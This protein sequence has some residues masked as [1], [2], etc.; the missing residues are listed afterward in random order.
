MHLVKDNLVRM[1][2]APKA[3]NE[4]EGGHDGNSKL[5]V[6]FTTLLLRLV[7]LDLLG[8]TGNLFGQRFRVR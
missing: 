8:D 5:V 3:R 1:P 2:D 6:P 7:R 4:S